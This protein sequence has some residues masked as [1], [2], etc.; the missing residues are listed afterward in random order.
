MCVCDVVVGVLCERT[1][2]FMYQPHMKMY[3]SRSAKIYKKKI[4]PMSQ[5]GSRD[6]GGQPWMDYTIYGVK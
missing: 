1:C 6:V 2:T 4:R 3:L 5:Y